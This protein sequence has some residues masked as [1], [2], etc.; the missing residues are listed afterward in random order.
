MNAVTKSGV[1]SKTYKKDI[2]NDDNNQVA[3]NAF[4]LSINK[5]NNIKQIWWG[6]N[7]YT[8]CLPSSECWIVWDKNNG[9][10]DQVDCELAWT[11]FRSVV[12][13]FTLSSEKTSRVHPNQKPLKLIQDIF[14]KFDKDSNYKNVIDLFRR[15]RIDI[16]SL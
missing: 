12:R 10:S 14:S 11:N 15:K 8:E 5:F 7:Y 4:K 1:L 2:L 9:N 13:Q 16:D 3:I 6:A